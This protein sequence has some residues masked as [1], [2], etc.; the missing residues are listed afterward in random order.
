VKH[1]ADSIKI[2]LI[3]ALIQHILG[4]SKNSPLPGPQDLFQPLIT[5]SHTTLLECD[6][7]IH[8][9]NS[10][11]FSD[12]DISRCNLV[13]CLFQDGLAKLRTETV[14]GESG[15]LGI[16]LGSVTCSFRRE[17]KPY[18][19]FEVWSRV[20]CWD[21]KWLYVVSH[22][23]KKG[24]VKPK[25]YTLQDGR[26]KSWLGS[27]ISRKNMSQENQAT[28]K[29]STEESTS[30]N[31]TATAPNGTPTAPAAAPDK[32]IYASALSR[33]VFKKDRLTIPPERVLRD[34]NLLPTNPAE[35][36][37]P[38]TSSEKQSNETTSSPTP[39]SIEVLL[40]SS[41]EAKSTDI[42]DIWDWNRIE[43]ERTRGMKIAQLM[44]DLNELDDEFSGNKIASLGEYRD[45]FWT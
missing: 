7:N 24:T 10:T 13:T 11:Y 21:R 32:A 39:T 36:A 45:L 41:L 26:P 8:K 4:R 18:E 25:G 19:R 34:S 43:Q 20:L 30:K 12:L 38:Q 6:Y 40:D 2:R 33:Y 42:N 29:S 15:R 1:T 3:N 17:I 31:G 37:P 22:F 27:L 14:E 5:S 28:E 9:S 44:A 16:M 35:S 23:V